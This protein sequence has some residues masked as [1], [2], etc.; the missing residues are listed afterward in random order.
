MSKQ[1]EATVNVPEPKHAKV[2]HIE[3]EA[4]YDADV[5]NESKADVR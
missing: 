1:L 4:T 2:R 3:S 5:G